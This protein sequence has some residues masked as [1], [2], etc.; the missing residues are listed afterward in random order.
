MKKHQVSNS[1]PSV[2]NQEDACD[3]CECQGKIDELTQALET[4]RAATEE[5]KNKCMR[6]L[7]DYQNL[8]RR[9][10]QEKDEVRQYA[11]E[12]IM[13]R[14]LSVV[15]TFSQVKAHIKDVGFDLAYKELIA[16]LEERGVKRFDVMGSAFD[17]HRMDCVEVVEG[18]ENIVMEEILPGYMLFDKVLRVARVK[19]GKQADK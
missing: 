3:T 8:E 12:I 16:L 5:W 10:R 1:V 11:N 13:G 17:P 9:N 18:D 7:A 19:V 6:A 14:L 2:S 15:D 4:E